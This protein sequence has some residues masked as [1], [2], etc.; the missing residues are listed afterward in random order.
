MRA[1]LLSFLLLLCV[2]G[3][4][5]QASW[6]VITTQ[7]VGALDFYN[8]HHGLL[9]FQDPTHTVQRIDDSVLT[10]V[11]SA[12]DVVTGIVIQDSV[13]AWAT[14]NGIGLFHGRQHLWTLWTLSSSRSNLTL[15]HATPSHL[16]VYS[17]SQ[18]YYTRDGSTF[19][20]ASGIPR[21][22]S[23]RAMDHISDTTIFAVSQTTIYRSTNFGAA[24]Q[25]V[26]SGINACQSI[27]AD[28]IHSVVFAGG[29]TVRRSTDGGLTWQS[30]GVPP[31]F[32]WER[33]SGTVMGSHDCMGTLFVTDNTGLDFNTIRSTDQARTMV[34]VGIAPPSMRV[35]VRGW[36]FDRGSIF[37]WWDTTQLLAVSHDGL[38]SSITRSISPY[39][40]VQADSLFD[41]L[42]GP[43]VN[44]PINIHIAS[45]V[46]TGIRLDSITLIR[47]IGKIAKKKLLTDSLTG[48]SANTSLTYTPTDAGEDSVMLRLW[49]HG[50]EWGL[51]EHTDFAIVVET[52][53]EPAVFGPVSDLDFGTVSVDSPQ[54]RSFAIANQGCA[55]LRVDSV[56][57]TSPDVF[58]VNTPAM[59]ARLGADSAITV[60]VRFAPQASGLALESIEIGTN[61]GHRFIAAQGFGLKTSSSVEQAGDVGSGILVPN[62]A[63]TFVSIRNSKPSDAPIVIYDLLGRMVLQGTSKHGTVDVSTLPE[64]TYVIRI[65]QFVSRIVIAR[66]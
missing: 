63:N 29:D 20:L 66:P 9:S 59:P 18:L 4:P 37:W 14:V 12:P 34:D 55:I 7:R 15:L 53:A 24:W 11:F 46:C 62:P 1:S 51:R 36:T 45:S 6:Q 13:N 65:G 23:I 58:I 60:Y 42:C 50:G 43:Q 31:P 38:D 2:T 35:L 5:V 22:D 17:D 47:S 33:I 10:G 26:K 56:V 3:V 61:A 41:T 28:A 44:F 27:F 32:S 39:I 16:F 40:S 19:T 57:S 25:V 52:G 48:T 64:G 49:Y 8:A 30:I 21:G 54:I